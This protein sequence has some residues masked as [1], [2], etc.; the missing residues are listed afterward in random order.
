MSTTRKGKLARLPSA[1]REHL[2]QRLE[3]GEPACRMVGWLNA[4]PEVQAVLAAEFGGVPIN[5]QN[6]SRWKQGGY[7]DWQARQE[8]H[9]LAEQLRAEARPDGDGGH[10]PLSHTLT[11]WVA[12]RYAVATRRIPDT[13]DKETW[14]LLREMCADAVQLCRRD[15]I[16][17]RLD[18]DRAKRNQPSRRSNAVRP[19]E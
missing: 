6:L 19:S 9:S 4:L 8:T 3:N 1:V 16:A 2:N 7:R 10:P 11:E 5:E 15:Q 17:A 12:A 13:D 18:F 14:R